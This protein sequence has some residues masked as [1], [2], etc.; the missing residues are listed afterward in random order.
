MRRHPTRVLA[1][2][3]SLRTR[4]HNA[5]LLRAVAGSAPDWIDMSGGC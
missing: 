2:P 3:G 4:S 5:A 1:L